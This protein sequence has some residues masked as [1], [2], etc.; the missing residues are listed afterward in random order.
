L[1]LV[2]MTVCDVCGSSPTELV[3]IRLKDRN[4]VKDLCAAHVAELATNARAP[5]RGRP[6]GGARSKKLAGR[7]KSGKIT[8]RPASMKSVTAKP[9]RKALTDPAAIEKRRAALAKGRRTL[10]ARRAAKS[11]TG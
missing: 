11:K 1:A 2:V 6:A 5:K 4:L 3:G 9:R 8:A 7:S 10:A